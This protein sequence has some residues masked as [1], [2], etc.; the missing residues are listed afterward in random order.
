M[1]SRKNTSRKNAKEQKREKVPKSGL[2]RF[3]AK[4]LF[5][6]RTDDAKENKRVCEERIVT[7]EARSPRLALRTARAIGRKAQFTAESSFYKNFSGPA[8][9]AYMRNATGRIHFELVG[10]LDMVDLTSLC[11]PNEVWYDIRR[12]RV[13]VERLILSDERLL[14]H[15]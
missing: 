10:I 9:T 6:Y 11:E 3:S 1:I 8:Y 12:R 15:T 2:K 4:L 13:P 7:F 14:K 5:Q